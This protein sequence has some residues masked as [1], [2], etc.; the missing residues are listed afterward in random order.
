MYNFSFYM[1]FLLLRVLSNIFDFQESKWA[2]LPKFGKVS[3]KFGN[4]SDPFK[5][6][7]RIDEGVWTLNI[8]YEMI[9]IHFSSGSRERLHTYWLSLRATADLW[10]RG[11]DVTRGQSILFYDLHKIATNSVKKILSQ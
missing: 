4:V 11:I 9:A 10:I 5:G 3:P 6:Y 1:L 7:G 2:F 8:R